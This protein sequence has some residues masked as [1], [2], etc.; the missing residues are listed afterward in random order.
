M[1]KEDM[2]AIALALGLPVNEKA[3]ADKKLLIEKINELI[4]TDFEKLVSILYRIDVNETKIKAF[5]G[6]QSNKDAAEIIAALMLER[7]IEKRKSRQRYSKRDNDIDEYE[8]W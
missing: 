8:K 4:L 5:L 7:E 1:Q 2:N 3:A 6:Q